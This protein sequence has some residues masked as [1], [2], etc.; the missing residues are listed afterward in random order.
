[1]HQIPNCPEICPSYTFQEVIKLNDDELTDRIFKAINRKLSGE[2]SERSNV[3]GFLSDHALNARF[4]DNHYAKL[5]SYY[6]LL[7]ALVLDMAQ[8]TSDVNA[9]MNVEYQVTIREFS[10]YLPDLNDSYKRESKESYKRRLEAKFDPE[11]FKEMIDSSSS[12]EAISDEN[13]GRLKD[14]VDEIWSKIY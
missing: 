7:M 3:V 5:L 2:E 4:G 6:L 13:R 10:K 8:T 1:M 11:T 9:E 12:P 14:L